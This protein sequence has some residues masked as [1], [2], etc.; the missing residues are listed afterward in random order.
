MAIVKPERPRD[1][2]FIIR[3]KFKV[4]YLTLR[5]ITAFLLVRKIIV[6]QVDINCEITVYK[7]APETP[8]FKTNINIGS[9]IM[10]ITAP[11][12]TVSIPVLPKP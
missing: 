9:R 3:L 11:I 6:Q 12:A 1:V 5:G 8:I 2:I 7:A 4:I 10:F